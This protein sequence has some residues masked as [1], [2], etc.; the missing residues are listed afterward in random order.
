MNRRHSAGEMAAWVIIAA[1][2]LLSLLLARTAGAAVNGEASIEIHNRDTYVPMP[3]LKLTSKT[4]IEGPVA[5]TR[6]TYLAE[7]RNE[8]RIEATVNLHVPRNTVLTAFGYYYGDRFIP[9]KMYDKDEA[10]KIYSAV[11]SRGRDPGIMDRPTQQDYHAQIFP[12]EPKRDLTVVIELVQMLPMDDAGSHFELPITQ[13]RADGGRNGELREIAV[14]AEVLVRDHAPDEVSENLTPPDPPEAEETATV[15]EEA[16]RG[17]TM[18][19]LARRF[20]PS[21][22]WKIDLKRET[23]GFETALF[24]RMVGYGEGYYALA[25]SAPRGLRNPRLVLRSRPG[26]SLSLPT[27]FNDTEAFDGLHV[28]GRYSGRQ[29]LYVTLLADNAKP[30]Y[31]HVDLSGE[32]VETLADNPAAALWADKRIAALNDATRRDFRPNIIRLSKRFSVVSPYTALL[33]IPKEEL[34]YYRKVL[35]KQKIKTNTQWTG[36]GGGDPYIEVKAPVDADRVVAVFPT[37]EVKELVLDTE[38]QAWTGRF[39]IPFGTPAGE[40]R[41][42][43]IVVHRGG[44]RSRFV[45]VYQNLLSAPTV[46]AGTGTTITAKRGAAVSVSVSGTGIRR[47]VAVAPWGER[48]DLSGK[49]GEWKGTLT[50]PKDWAAG[51]TRITVVLLDGAHNRTEVTLDVDVTDA[52]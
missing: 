45:L 16:V 34:D 11:T 52:P 5:R 28:V 40:Y 23:D 9:G 42:T 49:T 33:A 27:R 51:K 43:I 22:N 20:T 25:V 26:T 46:A 15:T 47:A 19:R 50:I 18:L 7:N 4:V 36:G 44:E 1:T 17:G 48:V 6:I 24:S 2:A 8:Q 32:R 12:V 3:L 29:R 10:W 21:D 37:G 31:F 30:R 41:V 35:A 14:D 38:K 39:D 13:G